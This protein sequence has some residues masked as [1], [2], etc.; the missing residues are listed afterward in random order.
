MAEA[1]AQAKKDAA[2]SP[3][4]WEHVLDL[5]CELTVELELPSFRLE[6][7]LALEEKSVVDWHWKVGNDVPVRVNGVLVAWGEFEVASDHLA[8][9][10]T[11]LA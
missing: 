7:V 10:F 4:G 6:E 1:A 9:R 2:A 5:S 11:D 3:P 8:V